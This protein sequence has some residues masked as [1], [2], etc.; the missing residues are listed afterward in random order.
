MDPVIKEEQTPATTEGATIETAEPKAI[1][2]Q[3][4]IKAALE[5]ATKEFKTQISGLDKKNTELQKA[6]KE[7]EL[8][9]KTEEEKAEALRQER[10]QLL[11]ENA[12]I[13]RDRIVDKKLNDAGLPLD[14]AK[15]IIGDEESE[16]LEDITAFKDYIEKAAQ[17]KADS[18]IAERMSG[19][20]PEGGDAPTGNTISN[21][22]FM[23]LSAKEKAAFMAKGGKISAA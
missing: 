13:L 1:D 19:K 23:A 5:E 22:E 16:I 18:I 17:S 12:R 7:K 20:K 2:I 21:A 11:K 4:E 6:L 9:G 10:E 8:E 15:R 14:F 3:A